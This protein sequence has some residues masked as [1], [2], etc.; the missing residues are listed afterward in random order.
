MTYQNKAGMLYTGGGSMSSQRVRVQKG[1]TLIEMMVAI[2]I[3]CILMMMAIPT[4]R[5][6]QQEQ[7][8]AAKVEAVISELDM[9][10]TSAQQMN[11]MVSIRPLDG[12]WNKGFQVFVND[13]FGADPTTVADSDLLSQFDTIDDKIRLEV[14]DT[15]G[16]NAAGNIRFLP[17]GMSGLVAVG[18]TSASGDAV[19]GLCRV[20]GGKVHTWRI[21]MRTSGDIDKTRCVKSQGVDCGVCAGL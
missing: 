3:A 15:A 14:L 17:N 10:R 16:G 8:L 20:I 5:D 4:M 18:K 21:T 2:G 12:S 11:K 1:F 6:W 13:S 19:I 7:D 9:A